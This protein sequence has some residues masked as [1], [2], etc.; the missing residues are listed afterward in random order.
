MP[1]VANQ[2]RVRG[3]STA[4]IHRRERKIVIIAILSALGEG[5][6]AVSFL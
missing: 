6:I 4:A 5:P 3:T 2:M 1:S